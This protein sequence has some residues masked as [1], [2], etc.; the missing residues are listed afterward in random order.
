[1]LASNVTPAD[2]YF[3]GEA[4]ILAERNRIKLVTIANPPLAALTAG[5]LN[6]NPDD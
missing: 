2:V 5:C 1:M 3:G 4:T 6:S